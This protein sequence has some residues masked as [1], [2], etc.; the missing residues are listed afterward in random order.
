MLFS[1][2]YQIDYTVI[3]KIFAWINISFDIINDLVKM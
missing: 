2:G 1:T 3:F